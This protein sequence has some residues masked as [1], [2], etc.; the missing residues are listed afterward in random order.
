MPLELANFF[1]EFLTDPEDIVLD[2]FAGSNTTGFCAEKLSRK[3]MSIETIKEYGKQSIMRFE[4]PS[5]K[6]KLI[7]DEVENK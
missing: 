2:P 5:I 6:T 1:I 4:D 3:W 7:F